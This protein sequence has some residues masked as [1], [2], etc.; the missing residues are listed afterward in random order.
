MKKVW[1]VG[2]HFNGFDAP[3]AV[4]ATEEELVAYM[5]S[6]LGFQYGYTAMA[7]YEVEAWKACRL[8]IYMA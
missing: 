7:E 2:Y 3:I 5:K 6:E 4:Y 1:K 8:K